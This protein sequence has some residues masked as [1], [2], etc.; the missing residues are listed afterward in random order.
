MNLQTFSAL[1]SKAI[2]LPQ[3]ITTTGDNDS[4]LLWGRGAVLLTTETSEDLS[5][6]TERLLCHI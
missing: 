1:Q 3:V 5:G 4:D 2:T 6:L